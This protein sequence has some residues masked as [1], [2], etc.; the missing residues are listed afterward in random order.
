MKLPAGGAS[1]DPTSPAVGAVTEADVKNDLPP[2]Y[3]DPAQTIL[4]YTVTGDGKPIEIKLDSK[5]KK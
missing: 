1:D 5:K 3:S 4:S 2:I